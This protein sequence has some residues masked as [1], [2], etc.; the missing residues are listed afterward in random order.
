MNAYLNKNSGKL[1]VAVLAMFMIVAGIA[2]VFSDSEVNASANPEIQETLTESQTITL[3][4]ETS[5]DLMVGLKDK[6]YS[7]T[8]TTPVTL[9]IN[10]AATA[11]KS[12]MFYNSSI[13]VGENVTLILNMTADQVYTNN[14]ILYNSSITIN[15]GT[16]EFRQSANN[17]GQTWYNDSSATNN[18]LAMT[19][20][21]SKL[22]F[23]G[24]NGISG[25]VANVDNG[26]IDFQSTTSSRAA[27]NFA[28]A[29]FGAG[30]SVT[31]TDP[32]GYFYFPGV[33]S[34]Y[35]TLDSGSS[36]IW[37]TST[38]TVTVGATGVVNS[39]N[40][41]NSAT[42]FTVTD[43]AKINGPASVNS[44]ELVDFEKFDEVTISDA[45]LTSVPDNF[46]VPANK[47]LNIVN[48]TIEPS[49]STTPTCTSA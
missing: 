29:Y 40:I 41:V 45:N 15:G 34:I 8:A 32:N 9:T 17:Q 24:A 26:K 37:F 36:D 3:T 38:A 43:G 2:V 1:L 46:E 28:S 10:M 30:T 31:M 6:T 33:T 25:V 11:D 47:I 4:G 27:L 42:N 20:E 19:G 7:F 39:A 18:A 12:I 49:T 44:L 14:H 22:V 48:S 16:V 35:G 23:N 5:G 13:T 21:T